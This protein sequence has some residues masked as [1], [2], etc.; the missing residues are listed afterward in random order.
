M[1]MPVCL[2]RSLMQQRALPSLG[3]CGNAYVH[4]RPSVL[5]STTMTSVNGYGPGRP[6]VSKSAV[7]KRLAWN[8]RLLNFHALVVSV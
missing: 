5:R 7:E 8:L 1:H 4:S 2:R 6:P 3:T